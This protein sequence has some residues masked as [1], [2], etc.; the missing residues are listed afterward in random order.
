MV[1]LTSLSDSSSSMKKSGA[2]FLFARLGAVGFAFALR[3]YPVAVPSPPYLFKYPPNIVINSRVA[4][5]LSPKI[6]LITA[7]SS[8]ADALNSL[9]AS[10]RPNAFPDPGPDFFWVL[11]AVVSPS[12]SLVI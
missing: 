3:F 9:R 1:T 4:L 10:L 8:A 5:V 2:A 7:I 6:S 11:T 12:V